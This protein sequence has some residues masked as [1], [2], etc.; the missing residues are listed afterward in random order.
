VFANK[1]N[2]NSPRKKSM[3]GRTEKGFREEKGDS[4]PQGKTPHL[5]WK[6]KGKIG[7]QNKKKRTPL[8]ENV[9]E[10]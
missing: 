7:N 5:K 3:D 6:K 2:A 1:K 9:T 8:S 10:T 4:G